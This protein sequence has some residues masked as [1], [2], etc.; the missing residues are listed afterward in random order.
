M[1]GGTSTKRA[2]VNTAV[3]KAGLVSARVRLS[4]DAARLRCRTDALNSERERRETSQPTP[5]ARRVHLPRVS[6]RLL[7]AGVWGTGRSCRRLRQVNG[8]PCRVCTLSE[9]QRGL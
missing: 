1:S 2:R 6:S 3:D 5:G 8:G 9:Y 7:V 4:V